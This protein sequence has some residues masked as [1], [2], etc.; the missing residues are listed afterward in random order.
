M[1]DCLSK[2][3]IHLKN[4][5]NINGEEKQSINVPCGKCARCIERRKMEWSFRMEYEMDISKTAYFITLTYDTKH[6]PINSKGVKTLNNKEHV[7]EETGEVTGG[8]LTK[9]F[10][11]LRVNQERT[12][13]TKEHLFNNLKPGDKIRFYAAGEY[14]TLRKRPHYHAIIFNASESVILKSWKLGDVHIV[15]ANRHTIAYVMKYLDK[16]LDAKQ[17][18]RKEAEFNTMSEGIGES[19]L[20]NMKGW[21]K[22]N[23]DVLFVT[24]RSGIKIPMPRYYRL[25]IFD[26]TERQY[27]VQIVESLM[28][29]KINEGI[30]RVGAEKYWIEHWQ[31]EKVSENNFKKKR[32]S[33]PVD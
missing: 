28:A 24:L 2:I 27:Q 26:E 1:A 17:D 31:R 33:R 25:K 29:E 12:D 32:K 9:F 21:H 20:D 16:S 23:L 11:R 14:G 22:R 15:P 7:N 10:K 8:D 5:I 4:P 6:V 13:V 3:P 30:D 19:Y 18:K